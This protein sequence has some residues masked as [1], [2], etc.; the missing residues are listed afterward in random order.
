[1]IA[2]WQV[3]Q[4][5]AGMVPTC[6]ANVRMCLRRWFGQVQVV[7]EG[8]PHADCM[9]GL[10]GQVRAL[11]GSERIDANA[12]VYW[13]T[14]GVEATPLQHAVHVGHVDVVRALVSDATVA[15]GSRVVP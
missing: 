9:L 8:R 1:M 14:T 3:R 5:G 10:V 7:K 6:S 12:P 11:L 4:G 13:V 2:I 15:S